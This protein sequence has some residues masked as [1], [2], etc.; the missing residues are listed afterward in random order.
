MTPSCFT[1]NCV[2]LAAHLAAALLAAISAGA[3]AQPAP[4]KP[5]KAAL[6]VTLVTPQ[7]ADL[8][9]RLAANGNITAWQEASVGAEIGGLRLTDVLVNVGDRVKRG[10]LLA[11]FDAATVAAE[12]AAARASLAE[13]E[14]ALAD[15]RA[16]AQRARAV[17]ASG[18]LSQQ[19]IT[20]LYT[21]EKSA[22][23]RTATQ[24]AQL[25]LQE[26][27]L[28]HAR[29]RAPD[30]GTISARSATVGAVGQPGQELFRLI[31]KNRLEWRAEVTAAEVARIRPGLE[32][33]ITSA[34][35]DSARG[36][37]RTV[38]PTVDTQ[39]RTALIYVDLAVPASAGA[40]FK[41]GMFAKGEFILGQSGA[42]TVPQAS[43]S[44][45]DGFSYVFVVGADNRAAQVKVV[46]GRQAGDQIEITG[47]L[48]GGERVVASGA[49][50]LTDGDTVK[51]VAK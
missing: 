50:F 1:R 45:R 33:V 7:Q 36:R 48:K 5:V 16:N 13:A 29:V 28:A 14:A 38:A 19:Q 26:L 23:A 8:P 10:Q 15:A 12:V 31:R 9:L 46:P 43:L 32:A 39:T 4:P 22:Q 24:K 21:A 40:G 2:R 49:A 20:Q 17:E 27:R 42:L 30:E 44:L 6:T 11:R 34:T 47:G 51:V 41:A 3:F 18:A 35:G 25:T 37:V